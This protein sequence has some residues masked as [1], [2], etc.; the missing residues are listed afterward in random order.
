MKQIILKSK[1]IFIAIFFSIFIISTSCGSDKEIPS[2]CIS[3]KAPVLDKP[4]K[5]EGK[6]LSTVSLGEKLMF[7]DD[8]EEEKGK[9]FLKVKLLDGNEGWIMADYVAVEARPAVI[10]EKSDIYSRPDLST[11]TKKTFNEMDVIAIISKKDDWIEVAGKRG[12]AKGIEK[13]W[14]KDKGYSEGTTDIA[15]AIFI[16][17]ALAITKSADRL[18]EL[19]SIMENS[20]LSGSSFQYIVIN[21]IRKIDP[22]AYPEDIAEDYELEEEDVQQDSTAKN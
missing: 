17:R 5:K 15:A 19:K 6:I 11:I 16:N 21:E 7:L 12:K 4:S 13:G 20:N 14:I 8:K 10:I 2:V 1:F 22:S 18:T 3:D 9:Q